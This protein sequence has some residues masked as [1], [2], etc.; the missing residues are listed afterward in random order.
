MKGHYKPDMI[1]IAG[2]LCSCSLVENDE[3]RAFLKGCVGIALTYFSLGNHEY[4]L[5]KKDI[6]EMES[7]GGKLD[8]G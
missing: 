1:C 2:D 7:I 5:D 8:V 3:I 4:L 6:E